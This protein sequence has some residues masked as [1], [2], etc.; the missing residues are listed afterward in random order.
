VGRALAWPPVCRRDTPLERPAVILLP[1]KS[2]DDFKIWASRLLQKQPLNRL[3]TSRIVHLAGSPMLHDIYLH[4]A[5]MTTAAEE[6][7]KVIF[8]DDVDYAD[9]Y[10]RVRGQLATGGAEIES[11]YPEEYGVEESTALLLYALVREARPAVVLEVGVAN[12][13]STQVILSALDTNG[14]GQLVSVDI[15]PRAG[16][17]ARGHPRWSLRVHTGGKS[18][19][20]ELRQLM[21]ELGPVD[22]FFHD[23]GHSYSE[24]Y[25]EYLIGLEYLRPGGLFVSDDVDMS[26]AFL[27]VARRANV[28][29]VALTDRRKVVG[30]FRRT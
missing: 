7:V 2:P 25:S 28:R 4:S 12:G 13:R 9:E 10:K 20:R 27:D 21:E 29:P 26:F 15:D 19:T 17:P 11:I 22:F 3:F 24:Q 18:S 23:A 1:V 8:G 5:V 16:G 14:A 30:L 6:A